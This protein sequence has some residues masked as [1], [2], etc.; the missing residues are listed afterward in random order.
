L[1]GSE[2]HTVRLWDT[3][4]LTCLKIFREHTAGIDLKRLVMLSPTLFASASHDITLK[5]WNIENEK[6]LKTL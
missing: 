5:I 6:S 2:D 1:S 3:D 4:Q